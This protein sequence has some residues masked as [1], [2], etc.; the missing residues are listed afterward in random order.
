[1]VLK[2]YVTFGGIDKVATL[3][4][5]F[6]EYDKQILINRLIFPDKYVVYL[7]N[8]FVG[9][10]KQRDNSVVLSHLSKDYQLN[11]EETSTND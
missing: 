2:N 3:S 9:L 4:K 7:D 11:W 10:A 1:M 6:D 5:D 8:A